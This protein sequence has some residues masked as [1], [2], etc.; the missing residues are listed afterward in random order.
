MLSDAGP[1]FGP[2]VIKFAHSSCNQASRV[3]PTFLKGS[4]SVVVKD[5]AGEKQMGEW[6]QIAYI[7]EKQ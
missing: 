1:P 3:I 5:D 6:V 4:G 2:H 7:I